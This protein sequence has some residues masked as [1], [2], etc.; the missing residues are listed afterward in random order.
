MARE[1]TG[2]MVDIV[3]D[4]CERKRGRVDPMLATE[5]EIKQELDVRGMSWM[6]ETFEEMR[7]A[8]VTHPRIKTIRTLNHI[9]YAYYT[10]ADEEGLL[11]TEGDAGSTTTCQHD[12]LPES[13][14]AQGEE[15][16]PRSTSPMCG[17]PGE[18]GDNTSDDSGS[19]QTNQYWWCE[20]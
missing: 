5:L 20:I 18:G 16:L 17:V 9:A 3:R 13:A 2:S 12:V 19:H 14:V 4:I 6:T 1:T 7:R 10:E 15:K 11:A 8:L